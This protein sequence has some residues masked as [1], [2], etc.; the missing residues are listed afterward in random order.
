[1]IITI[2][3]SFASLVF[4]VAT[5]NERLNYT[6]AEQDKMK[7]KIE[8]HDLAITEIQTDIKYI[9]LG[10]DEIKREVKKQNGN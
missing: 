9:R 3:I 7:A 8:S 1:M 10:I 6:C 5:Q 2:T 4:A